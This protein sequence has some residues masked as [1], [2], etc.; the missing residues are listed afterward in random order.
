[1]GVVDTFTT[2]ATTSSSSLALTVPR[3]VAAGSSI[4]LA[5][6]RA[7]TSG[8]PVG[9]ASIV[10]SRSNT[11]VLNDAGSMRSGNEEVVVSHAHLT[12]GLQV[13]DTITVTWNATNTRHL[14]VAHA[15]S[16]LSAVAAEATSGTTLT[17]NTSTGLNGSSSAPSGSTAGSTTSAQCVVI[18]AVA[19]SNPAAAP[20]SA[21]TGYTSGGSVVTT[22]GSGDRGL[23]TEYKTTSVAGVQTAG[24]SFSASSV[25]A[26]AIAA[27]PL[28]S[29]VPT[30][31]AG[32]DQLK[33]GGEL[34]TLAAT[35]TGTT[36]G[37]AW[38]QVSGTAVTLTTINSTT[39]SYAA[40]LTNV[41][42]VARVFRYTATYSG[43]SVV[44]DVAVTTARSPVLTAKTG[45]FTAAQGY[46]V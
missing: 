30:V 7:D 3:A 5:A 1:M 24:F 38:S 11:W 44:D 14:I 9:L 46:T 12:T 22:I 2:S 34:V 17:L 15:V 26:E 28:A 45:A 10:D 27:Y 40:E 4:V 19:F 31:D 23:A 29:A 20:V 41:A 16:G 13:G 6:E 8:N 18:A 35:V 33:F 39:S 42:D 21:G 25:W 32:D 43:G 36:T 37:G